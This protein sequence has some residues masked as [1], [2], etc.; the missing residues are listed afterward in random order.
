MRN[1]QTAAS[2]HPL[3]IGQMF[4]WTYLLGIVHTTTSQN[5]CYSSWNTPYNNGKIDNNAGLLGIK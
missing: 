5:I 1:I 3:Q 2:P 4:I